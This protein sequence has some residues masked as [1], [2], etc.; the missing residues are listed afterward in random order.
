MRISAKIAIASK[1]LADYKIKVPILEKKENIELEKL[2]SG[3]EI[4]G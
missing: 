1:F 2:C 4:K 3:V